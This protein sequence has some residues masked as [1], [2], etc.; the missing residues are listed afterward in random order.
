MAT[1]RGGATT[2][3]AFRCARPGC[4][5]EIEPTGRARHQLYCSPACRVGAFQ[6]RA[7]VELKR[8][9]CRNCSQPFMPDRATARFCSPECRWAFNGSQA[10]GARAERKAATRR[11]ARKKKAAAPRRPTAAR[12]GASRARS[13]SRR[14]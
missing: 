6:G 10:S 8:R 12:A 3:R 2:R 1:K 14:A 7:K 5:N 9:P 11:A 4:S 13:R